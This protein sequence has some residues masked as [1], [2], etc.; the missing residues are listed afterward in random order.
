M[1]FDMFAPEHHFDGDRI[2]KQKKTAGSN[3]V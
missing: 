1:A 3:E 2:I